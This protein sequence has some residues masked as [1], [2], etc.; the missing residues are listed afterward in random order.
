MASF[1][2]ILLVCAVFDDSA[3]PA[4]WNE[5]L[6]L[7][8][9]LSDQTIRWRSEGWGD[10][11]VGKYGLTVGEDA[12]ADSPVPKFMLWGDSM[13]EALQVPDRDKITFVFNR[14]SGGDPVHGIS[15]GRGGMGVADYYFIMPHYQRVV[16]NVQANVVL[17]R[18]FNDVTP[19]M[20]SGT[21]ARFHCDPLGFDDSTMAV[22]TWAGLVIGPWIRALYLEPLH[23]LY[24]G[25]RRHNFRFAPSTATQA[26]AQPGT[27]SSD[28]DLEQAWRYLVA[29]MKQRSGV[30]LSFVYCPPDSPAF[31]DGKVFVQAGPVPE[32]E[33]FRS[34]CKESGVGF[35]D[36]TPRFNAHYEQT[37]RFPRG[38]FNSPPGTG[39]LNAEGQRMI[40]EALLEYF[41]EQSQ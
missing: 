27:V 36:M 34:I 31:R 16:S 4:E 41:R 29:E 25:L 18:G 10:T 35:I 38:F 6:Q 37:G 17:L 21:H 13:V 19:M 14:I 30:P 28:C 32:V 7:Y 3:T 20:D 39:H 2:F 22:P 12:L 33:L 15:W 1:A 11:R 8:T 40:A 24:A 5:S 26:L 9:R 23:F